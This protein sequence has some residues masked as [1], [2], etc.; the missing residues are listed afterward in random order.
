MFTSFSN[1]SINA[2]KLVYDITLID[3]FIGFKHA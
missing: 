3:F 1:A 2:V